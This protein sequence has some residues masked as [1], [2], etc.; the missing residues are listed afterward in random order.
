[1]FFLCTVKILTGQTPEPLWLMSMG[2][3]V[4]SINMSS[5]STFAPHTTVASSLDGQFHP[6]CGDNLQVLSFCFFLFR[7]LEERMCKI[8][9]EVIKT[10]ELS[11]SLSSAFPTAQTQVRGLTSPTVF[12][13][14]CSVLITSSSPLPRAKFCTNRN[15]GN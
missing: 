6:T 10:K 7:I 14:F 13:K 1:M 11:C 8:L 15:K 12:A 4:L 2:P 3:P 5:I 9:Y